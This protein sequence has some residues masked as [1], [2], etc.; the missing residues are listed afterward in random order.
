MKKVLYFTLIGFSVLF[1]SCEKNID[2]DF[3]PGESPYV[4]E[5]YI[6]NNQPPIITISRGISFLSNISSDDFKNLFVENATV[7]IAVNNGAPVVLNKINISGIIIYT[8]PFILGKVGEVYDLI[9]EVDG[10]TF[11]SST[12]I[13]PPNPLDS[14][15]IKPAPQERYTRDSLVELIAN[16]K[17]PN[18]KGN[19]YRL[20]TKR[21]TDF[22]FDTSFN[23]V[24]DDLYWNG[25]KI[26]FTI[27]RG[28]SE[29]Q[30]NDSAD[31]STFGYFKRGDTVYV[32]WASI[33]KSQYDF[34]NTFESQSNSFGN[35]FTSTIVIKSNIK[36][37]GSVGIWASYGA[38]IDT[39]IIP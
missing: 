10:K 37:K 35:P 22:F 9:I 23:S 29:F 25:T 39:L 3:P 7:K 4:I 11:T 32:K 18:P 13:L 21:N 2:I 28:K 27:F 34:W 36:G 33:D 20:L 14:I 15:S 1:F 24:F 26:Q 38:F 12:K 30:N 17:E 5:G 8:S 19:Y 31:F 16:F 6:E